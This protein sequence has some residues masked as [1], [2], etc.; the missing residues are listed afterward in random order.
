MVIINVATHDIQK[1]AVFL[2]KAGFVALIMC[3]NNYATKLNMLK[4]ASINV[5]S[6]KVHV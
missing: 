4:V 1:L 5:I 3:I 6:I 2:V